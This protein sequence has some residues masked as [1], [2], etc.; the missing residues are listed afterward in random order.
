MLDVSLAAVLIVRAFC[1]LFWLQPKL[2][3][4]PA[5]LY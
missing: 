5:Q 1:L 2:K 4:G 3:V